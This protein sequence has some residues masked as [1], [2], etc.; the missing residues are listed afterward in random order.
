MGTHLHTSELVSLPTKKRNSLVRRKSKNYTFLLKDIS[1]H[2]KAPIYIPS[3]LTR[4][5]T[6]FGKVLFIIRT[7]VP[8]TFVQATVKWCWFHV[9]KCYVLLPYD[10]ITTLTALQRATEP[11]GMIK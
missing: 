6:H 5:G 1:R 10:A 3:K 7:E 9:R 8:H 2:I 4:F 11:S